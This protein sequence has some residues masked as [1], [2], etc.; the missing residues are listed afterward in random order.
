MTFTGAMS[1]I[2]SV[3]AGLRFTPTT[4]Y[5]VTAGPGNTGS[6]GTKT[7]SDTVN[8]TATKLATSR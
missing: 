2:N 8:I 4:N 1:D 3:L 5:W 6:G 7:D